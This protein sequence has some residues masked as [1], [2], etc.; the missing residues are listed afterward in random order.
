MAARERSQRYTRKKKPSRRAWAWAF[1]FLF[2]LIT[3]WVC[4]QR[5]G[6]LKPIA[7][8]SFEGVTI[9]ILSAEATDAITI[10]APFRDPT[11][12][13]QGL[14]ELKLL[15]PW[16]SLRERFIANNLKLSVRPSGNRGALGSEIRF[17]DKETKGLGLLFKLRAKNGQP[18]GNDSYWTGTRRERISR[19]SGVFDGTPPDGNPEYAFE[20]DDGNGR[21]I[22]MLGPIVV[23]SYDGRGGAMS[24]VFPRRSQA[25]K[26]R[27][28]KADSEVH[29]AE[30][31]NPA[32]RKTIA[33][34]LPEPLPAI[35]QTDEFT[36]TFKGFRS[37]EW[38]QWHSKIEHSD[39]AVPGAERATYSYSYILED[40]T[41]NRQFVHHGGS[42]VPSVIASSGTPPW[43]NGS[44]ILHSEPVQ[45]ITYESSGVAT[46]PTLRIK[47]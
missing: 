44:L 34:W 21:W 40:T 2:F 10:G 7:T 31:P 26:I 32:W 27:I 39:F 29:S 30:I 22:R 47:P 36:V 37:D 6:G 20:I 9:D 3:G 8:V 25:L 12:F 23:D 4:Y 45:R 42:C 15:P 13:R 14:V 33:E 17:Y 24:R 46:P 35:R 18:I 11:V 41:G 19:S 1:A 38:G 5:S 28:C 16:R 43:Q